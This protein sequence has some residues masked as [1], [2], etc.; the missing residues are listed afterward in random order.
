MDPSY[1]SN[2]L[3]LIATPVIGAIAGAVALIAGETLLDSARWGISAGGSGFLAWTIGRELH[4]D[5]AWIATVAA[6]GAPWGVLVARPDLISVA[7]VLLV[8]RS[9]ADTTGRALRPADVILLSVVGGF[10]VFRDPAPGVLAVGA[11]GLTLVALWSERGRTWA[12]VAAAL[13]V[14]G[15]SLSAFFADTV[16]PSDAGWV[17]LVAGA[18]AGFAALAGPGVVTVGTDRTG[19][20]IRGERV[21][22]ARLVALLMAAAATP[23]ADPAVMFPVF[24]ALAATAIRPR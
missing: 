22:T 2:V 5:R 1:P 10:A 13:Y 20:T 4:P 16:A 11:L 8:T 12:A 7:V 23:T 3:I 6:F 18:V 14:V 9:L 19:G 21:R 15:A 17:V 24:A